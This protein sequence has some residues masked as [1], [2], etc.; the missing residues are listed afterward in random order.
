MFPPA[1]RT[2]P[3][4]I[5]EFSGLEG[6]SLE[7]NIRKRE[8]TP[9]PPGERGRKGKALSKA[10]ALEGGKRRSPRYFLEGFGA[11]HSKQGDWKTSGE[12]QPAGWGRGG[13]S[14]GLWSLCVCVSARARARARVCVCVCLAPVQGD[15]P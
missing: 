13:G 15:F 5:W 2:F 14:V 1:L 9:D 11:E 8:R 6:K 3:A 10:G 7:R 12:D 4:Q